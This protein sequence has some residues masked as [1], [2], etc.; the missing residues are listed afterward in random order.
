[1]KRKI[2]FE[3]HLIDKGLLTEEDFSNILLDSK[4][5]SNNNQTFCRIAVELGLLNVRDFFKIYSFQ[6]STD[7]SIEEIAIKKGFLTPDQVKAIYAKI[8]ETTSDPIELLIQTKRISKKVIEFER[9]EF[10]NHSYEEKLKEQNKIKEILMKFEIFSHLKDNIFD[11]LSNIA[12][13]ENF[14]SGEIVIREGM[15]A[16]C[17]YCIASGELSITKARV[18]GNEASV[19]KTTTQRA[20]SKDLYIS[21]LT[22]GAVLGEASIFEKGKRTATVTAISDTTLIRFDRFPFLSFLR[23]YPKSSQSILIFIIQ[24]LLQRLYL[25]NK[26]LAFERKDSVSQ[27]DIDSILKEFYQA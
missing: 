17:I 20:K 5:P 8:D 21:S 19:K 7:N 24:G 9:A 18:D 10:Y 16:D 15:D 11:S 2:A 22:E 4:H 6:T 14:K 23:D 26:D 27:T 12:I 13:I 3:Q 1:M 25:T